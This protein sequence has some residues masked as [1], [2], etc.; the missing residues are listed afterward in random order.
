MDNVI[1]IDEGRSKK[2][3]VMAKYEN[4]STIE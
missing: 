2:E 1:D 4:S 3:R